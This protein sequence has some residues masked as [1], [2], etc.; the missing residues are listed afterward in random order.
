MPK[1]LRKKLSGSPKDPFRSNN[2][3]VSCQAHEPLL[4]CLYY[5]IISSVYH[6]PKLESKETK[7]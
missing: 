3:S 5:T 6:F 4:T 2:L 1:C 7:P